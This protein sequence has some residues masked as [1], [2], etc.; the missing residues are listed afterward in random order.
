MSSVYAVGKMY[1]VKAQFPARCCGQAFEP[2]DELELYAQTSKNRVLVTLGNSG[3]KVKFSTF[4]RC[5]EL[6]D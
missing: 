6:C 1:K 4:R 5:T 2:G 3:H